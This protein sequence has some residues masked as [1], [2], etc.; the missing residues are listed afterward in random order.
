MSRQHGNAIEQQALDYL[1]RQGLKLVTRNF[2]T[3]MGEIDLVMQDGK[4]LVFVEVRY[5]KSPVFGNSAESVTW[6]KQ[7]KL[8]L[9]A[10]FFLQRNS[11][12]QNYPCRFDVIACSPGKNTADINWIKNAFQP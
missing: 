6:R 9:T 11:Q 10:E 12:M 1:S 7:K 5:R 4:T 2:T 8:T 3:R